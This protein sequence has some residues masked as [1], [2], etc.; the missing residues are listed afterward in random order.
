MA[1][2]TA[3]ADQVINPGESAIFTG[4]TIPCRRGFV[5]HSDETAD[6]LLSGAMTGNGCGCSCNCGCNAA[7]YLVD[8]SANIAV[9]TG[10]EAGAIAVAIGKNGVTIP[11]SQ[12]E[13]TPAA[14]EEFF[15]VSKAISVP[16]WAGC[17][18]TITVR[19]T[20]DQPILMS[21]AVI[22]ITRP[23]LVVTR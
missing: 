2:Y 22:R 3:V 19:N 4:T 20:S 18:E 7:E 5:R 23:D 16:I 17:C 10:G 9:D 21:N 14:V 13:V 11:A 15:A 12:M 6:F 1:E 8:F